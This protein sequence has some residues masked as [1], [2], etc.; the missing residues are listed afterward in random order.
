VVYGCRALLCELDVDDAWLVG[1]LLDESNSIA[2]VSPSSSSWLLMMYCLRC[3]CNC[4]LLLDNHS[5]WCNLSH[6]TCASC[7]E[8]ASDHLAIACG[9]FVE[10]KGV[11]L[12]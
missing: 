3:V 11:S 5:L 4:C 7:L 10:G 6:V 12:L 1:A 8:V 9:S 2:A